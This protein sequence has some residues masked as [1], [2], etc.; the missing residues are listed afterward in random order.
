MHTLHKSPSE[1]NKYQLLPESLCGV[2]Y[3]HIAQIHTMTQTS[4]KIILSIYLLLELLEKH[5]D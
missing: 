5:S 4:S 1:Q 3:L 2:Y